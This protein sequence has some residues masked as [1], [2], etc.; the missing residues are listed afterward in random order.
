M[1]IEIFCIRSLRIVHHHPHLKL[2]S[3]AIA[4]ARPHLSQP[5]EHTFKL[6]V[7]L[8]VEEPDR[9]KD[10]L[11]LHERMDVVTEKLV[12]LGEASFERICLWVKARIPDA[13]SVQIE[14][15]DEGAKIVF[16]EE[17]LS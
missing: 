17:T 8:R 4:A 16:D 7:G 11:L 5:H 15:H 2:V 1:K 3:K 9:E 10:L 12:D 14:Q 13:C 6:K